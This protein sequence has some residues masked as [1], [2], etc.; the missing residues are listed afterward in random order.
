MKKTGYYKRGYTFPTHEE[1]YFDM[2]NFDEW[3]VYLE[4]DNHR[5][6][7]KD[8]DYFNEIYDLGARYGFHKVYDSFLK[9]YGAVQSNNWGIE[10]RRKCE[11]VCKGVD[12][13]YEEDTL[14]LWFTFYMT[15]LAE[16][17]KE[18]TK[19]GK[20]IKNLA[21]YKILIL[22]RDIEK[23]TREMVGKKYYELQNEMDE[24]GLVRIDV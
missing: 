6:T 24:Y 16:E 15:M 9:V 3:C 14:K 11:R 17:N 4:K 13:E 19:L 20:T 1:I 10:D 22:Q 8:I 21:V 12:N 23:V 7:P 5:R 18:N 2:G